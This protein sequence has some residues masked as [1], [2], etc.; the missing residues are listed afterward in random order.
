MLF[1]LISGK[2]QNYCSCVCCKHSLN[3]YTEEV[4]DC[5]KMR[6]KMGYF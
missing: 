4:P 2:I 6:G 3:I 5:Y 1:A